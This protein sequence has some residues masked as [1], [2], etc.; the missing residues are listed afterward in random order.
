MKKKYVIIVPILILIEVL[1]VI[2]FVNGFGYNLF[3]LTTDQTEYYIDDSIRI[4]ASW[5]LNYNNNIEI[6]YIQIHIVDQF[7][8]FV[9]NSSQYDQIGPFEENW[10]VKIEDF[11]LNI[12]NSTFNLYIKFYIFYFHIDTASTMSNYL[13][14]IDIK[15]VKRKISCEL[16]GYKD[17]INLGESL[18]LE[19][20]FYDIVTNQF[21]TNQTIQFIVSFNDLIIHQY[22]YTTNMSGIIS[23]QLFSFTHLKLGHNNLIFSITNNKLYNDSIIIYEIYVDK[24]DPIIDILNFT[25]DLKK[26]EDLDLKLHCYYYINHSYKPIANFKILIEIFNNNSLTFIREYE[27]DNSGVLEIS[28]PQNNF[29]YDLNIQV[30][31]IQISLN[32]TQYLDNKILSLNL[33]LNQN[34][35]AEI[36]NSIQIKIFSF[37][38]VLIMILIFISYIIFNKKSKNEKLLTELIIRY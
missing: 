26:N 15:V 11:N 37:T 18:L 25:N 14:T 8:R 34:N 2:N 3:S 16:I 36:L 23:I 24:N 21:F 31:A 27:T 4:N 10:T 35:Y 7:D 29:N 6:A 13:D 20:H 32:E 12:E 5:E 33:Y 19:A 22:N 9:W 38:S 1:S 30:F 28:I 17:R